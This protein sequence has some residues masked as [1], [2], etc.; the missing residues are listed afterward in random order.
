[1]YNL[2][3]IFLVAFV[4]RIP[5]GSEYRGKTLRQKIRASLGHTALCATFL[6]SVT[7]ATQ[8]IHLGAD[9]K[10]ALLDTATL[11]IVIAIPAGIVAITMWA[12][13]RTPPL[14]EVQ[15]RNCQK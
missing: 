11:P 5:F 14:A 1:M 7:I 13:E 4:A 12:I 8:S 15:R 3:V 9:D 2:L 6:A 10:A